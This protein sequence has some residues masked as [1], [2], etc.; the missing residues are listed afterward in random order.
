MWKPEVFH[1][2][3]TLFR[4]VMDRTL[5]SLPIVFRLDDEMCRTRGLCSP[6]YTRMGGDQS[7]HFRMPH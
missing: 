3:H 6:K 5:P 1:A 4:A 2:C 7:E